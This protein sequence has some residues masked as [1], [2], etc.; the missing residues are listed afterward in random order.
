MKLKKVVQ[1]LCNFARP[2]E[3]CFCFLSH[4]HLR[5]FSFILN[6]KAELMDE[7]EI[8]DYTSVRIC[9]NANIPTC[10]FL[11]ISRWCLSEET[12]FNEGEGG[13]DPQALHHGIHLLR[14]LPRTRKITYFC[15]PLFCS[16]K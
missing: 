10:T 11:F 3:R 2:F 6:P 15:L 16:I 12:V 14:S 8:D 4:V 9:L 5:P 1:R 7:T 13:T